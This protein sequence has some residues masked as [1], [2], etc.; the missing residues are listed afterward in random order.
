VLSGLRRSWVK[1]AVHRQP[2]FYSYRGMSVVADS[3]L[4]DHASKK[5][6]T[7]SG[8]A[9]LEASPYLSKMDAGVEY[10]VQ[11]SEGER[12]SSDSGSDLRN[13]YVHL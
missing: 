8:A 13:I 10:P 3:E 6:R 12:R 4:A 1:A 2:S 5:R 11:L 7:E 9:D